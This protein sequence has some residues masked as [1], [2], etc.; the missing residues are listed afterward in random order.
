MYTKECILIK[1]IKAIFK[2]TG[3]ELHQF[4]SIHKR[5]IISVFFYK[6]K[7]IEECKWRRIGVEIDQLLVKN[8]SI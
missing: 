5:L 8:T 3:S 2:Q 6:K 7:R 1:Y 4:I